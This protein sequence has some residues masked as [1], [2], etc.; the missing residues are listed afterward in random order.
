MVIAAAT[1]IADGK[2]ART[3]GTVTRQGAVLDPIADTVLVMSVQIKLVAS[4]HLPAYLL[5][6]CCASV[7][8]YAVR[9]T[10]SQEIS[11]SY[12]GKY[13]GAA[14]MRAILLYLTCFMIDPGLWS[15][16]SRYVCPAIAVY[17]AFST[18]ENMFLFLEIGDV[19][20][21]S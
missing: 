9:S 11:R 3:T 21:P 10:R 14:L 1:D 13:V 6:M 19:Y 18:L 16:V 17:L 5:S 4:G 15:R 12:I 20:D 7:L 8:T 2:L